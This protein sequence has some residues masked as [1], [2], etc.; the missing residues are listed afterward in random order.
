MEKSRW[1][2]ID[3]MKSILC[4]LV[5]FGHSLTQTV[6]NNVF[7]DTIFYALYTFHMP[8]FFMVS[9]ITYMKY[10]ANYKI[11]DLM[12]KKFIRLIIPYFSMSIFAY[13]VVMILSKNIIPLRSVIEGIVFL[14]SHVDKHLWFIYVL[15]IITFMNCILKIEK[16]S[17]R[18]IIFLFTVI[19]AFSAYP[20]TESK[21]ML[22]TRVLYYNMYF[23]MGICIYNIMINKKSF[24]YKLI[25]INKK[26]WIFLFSI[27]I[28]VI[29]LIKIKGYSQYIKVFF[30]V[31]SSVSAYMVLYNFSNNIKSE[32]IRHIL[33]VIS[34][35]SYEIY[36]LHNPFIT[37]GTV[38]ILI[39]IFNVNYFIAVIVGLVTGIS[40]SILISKYLIRKSNILNF[41][42]TGKKIKF[43]IKKGYVSL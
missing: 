39:T 21:Y 31:I 8:V 20:L 9:G 40:V 13:C 43:D 12:R 6:R 11:K 26:V 17:H 35:Y 14:Y 19:L 30:L 41:L 42:V 2:E 3:I 16:K 4:I 10:E 34:K 24:Y 18:S 7:L 1:Q 28:C 15:F 23:Q 22:F 5:V 38:T 25:K 32:K 36:L 33:L 29:F 37:V 27:A